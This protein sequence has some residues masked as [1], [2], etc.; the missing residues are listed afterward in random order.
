MGEFFNHEYTEKVK[1]SNMCAKNQMEY[2]K[3]NEKN[4]HFLE[5]CFKEEK[6]TINFYYNIQDKKS[7][8]EIRREKKINR[9][10]ALLEIAEL[11]RIYIKFDISLSP[12]NLYYD[13]NFRVY[14]KRRDIYI[15]GTEGETETFIKKYKALI[16]HVMQKKYTYE[17]YEI[18]GDDLYHKTSFLRKMA[19]LKNIDEILEFL[20]EEY[21]HEE[22]ISMN[23]HV[24]VNKSWYQMSST[25]MLIMAIVIVLAIAYLSYLHIHLIPQKEALLQASSHY[26]EGSYVKVIDD[27]REIDLKNLDKYQKYILAVSYVKGESLTP[28]QKENILEKISIDGEEKIKEYWIYLGRLNTAE[29]QNIAMQRSDDEL[30]LYAYMTEK[31]IL[32]KNTQITGKEKTDRLNT[33]EKKIEELA[34][35]YEE[36]TDTE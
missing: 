20:K 21:E 29:A 26:M 5:C 36:T 12:D 15:R 1:K 16:G 4:I 30:L 24:E 27:L 9:L 35:K 25:C 18:G 22:D 3:L 13:K 17:D 19:V 7:F 2:N 34:K 31:A 32:E 8:L 23:K 11:M 10:R 6:E 33:L 28:E 14:V